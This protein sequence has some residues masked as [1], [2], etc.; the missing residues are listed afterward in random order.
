[1]L[2]LSLTRKTLVR[3]LAPFSSALSTVAR[4]VAEDEISPLANPASDGI[5]PLPGHSHAV[6]TSAGEEPVEITA[7]DVFGAAARLRG[8][9]PRTAIS[10]SRKLSAALGMDIY[11]KHEQTHATGSFKERGARNALLQLDSA[12]AKRGVAAASAGN[13]ALALAHHGALLG[14][15]VTV[16]MPTLAPLTKV[17]NCRELG[18]RVIVEGAHIGESR[19]AA[20]ALAER[21]G[22]TYINGFDHP[23]IIAGAGTLGL[24]AIEQ[25]PDLDAVVIPVGG[26]GL[27]A[28]V[29][30][31][32]K[33]LQPKVKIYGVEPENCPSLT[34]ALAAG[35]PVTVPA[36]ATL[37]DG[38]M[39]PRVGTN[40]FAIASRLVDGVVCVKESYI[41]LSMLR[42]LECE[43]VLIEG[44]GASGL[45]GLLAGLLPHLKGKRVLVPLCG[46]NVDTPVLGRVLERGLAADGRLI[47][48]EARVSDRPGGIAALTAV[49]AEAGVSVKEI[50]HERAWVAEDA[51]AVTI[52]IV[53]E[54]PTAAGGD[55]MFAMLKAKG[56]SLQKQS[57]H[58]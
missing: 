56:Y 23:H 6:K 16:V 21:E 49:L 55:L 33:T 14:V 58:Q 19:E 31:A 7:V 32:L 35:R 57:P 45:A 51:Y 12:A 10:H 1:M 5:H 48:F 46:G 43:K 34:L 24:E 37:A 9:L 3:G 29:A 13:H 4:V 11:F 17:Q 28:G 8:S 15:P 53:V 38:L 36:F 39:V 27:I 52:K 50:F 20:F 30:L 2:V 22:L 47:K 25:L 26:A 42:L 40:A 54:T 41:A 44:G 18:A